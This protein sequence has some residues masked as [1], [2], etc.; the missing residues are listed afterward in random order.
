MATLKAGEKTRQQILDATLRVI[1]EAGVDAVTHRRVGLHAD[2]SH[3]VVGYHFPKR[4][5]L[6]FQAFEY[7]LGSV[8][9]YAAKIGLRTGE[10]MNR[11]QVIDVLCNLVSEELIN[12]SSVRIDM[13]LTLH[14]TRHAKLAMMFSAWLDNGIAQLTQGL[15][16]SGFAKPQ[17]LAGG[18]SN[19]LRG[20]LIECLSNRELT[21]DHFR[22][23]VQT[24][25]VQTAWERCR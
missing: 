17:L 21:A 23:R 13:E 25:F 6:I 12:R 22:E 2:L 5:E 16:H 20:F 9:D 1:D 7:H 3:G 15:D 11:E 19:L 4:D 8:D 18:L 24:L 10:T 14:A